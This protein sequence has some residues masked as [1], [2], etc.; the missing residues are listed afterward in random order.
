MKKAKN[1]DEY[2]QSA[3][4]DIQPRLTRLRAVIL[5]VV[6][7]AEEKISYGMPYF[8][9]KGRLA[10]FSYFKHHIGLYVTPPVIENHAKELKEYVTAKATVQF[11][12]DKN[13]PIALIKKLVK[14]RVRI[15][16]DVHPEK[17]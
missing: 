16:E 11:P 15:N 3:P 1:V 14:A 9:Y 8:G 4:K 5:S 7:T 6:P 10:Y 13:L 12:L 2:I 17:K